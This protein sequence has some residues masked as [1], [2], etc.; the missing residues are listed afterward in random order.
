MRKLKSLTFIMF[1]CFF[2]ENAF[3]ETVYVVVNEKNTDIISPEMVKLIY[4]DKNSVW[5]DGTEILVFELPV[6]SEAREKFCQEV[7]NMSPISSQR[8]WSNRFV[9]NTIQ[10]EVKIK[11]HRLVTR[12]VSAK[13][14]AIGY[15]PESEIDNMQGV[16]IVM[17]I[18]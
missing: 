8:Y 10:N 18:N 3:S 14:S 1:L 16:R 5:S 6:K 2:S 15:I 12:F 17:T 7:L 11:P 9:N 13:E 4:L